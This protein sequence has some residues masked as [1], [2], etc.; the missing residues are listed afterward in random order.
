MNTSVFAGYN[1][2]SLIS[3][4]FELSLQN[5]RSFFAF[6]RRARASARQ[7]RS[8]RHARRE[9]REKNS[10]GFNMC[11]MQQNLT[12]VSVTSML[13]STLNESRCSQFHPLSLFFSRQ[14]V[15]RSKPSLS[16][17]ALWATIVSPQVTIAGLGIIFQQTRN[18]T[19]NT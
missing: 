10:D 1:R 8:A 6:F 13:R 17:V 19:P 9:G 14:F 11:R 12:S 5:R 7:A 2:P 3:C 15:P 18:K 4:C 16:D